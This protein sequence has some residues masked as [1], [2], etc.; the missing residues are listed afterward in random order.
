MKIEIGC[1]NSNCSL[2]YLESNVKKYMNQGKIF[3]EFLVLFKGQVTFHQYIKPKHAQFGIKLYELTTSNGIT[4]DLL[5]YCGKGMFYNDNFEELPQSE[6][7]PVS[8][9][10]SLCH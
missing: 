10:E 1:T 2:T 7:I 6:R 5:V 8:L 9:M 4:L 3:Y